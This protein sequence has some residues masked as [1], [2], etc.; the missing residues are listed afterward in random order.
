MNIHVNKHTR[1]QPWE[2]KTIFGDY[3]LHLRCGNM[4]VTLLFADAESI[5]RVY[6][7]L[8][9]LLTEVKGNDT[10]YDL[11]P[12]RNRTIPRLFP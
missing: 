8:A 1:L 11:G 7:M 4:T 5:Q 9:E 2:G 12:Q 10:L 6:D 3:P